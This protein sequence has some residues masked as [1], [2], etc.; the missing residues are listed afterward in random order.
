MGNPRSAPG[1]FLN[2]AAIQPLM[3]SAGLNKYSEMAVDTARNG[4][5]AEQP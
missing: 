4:H 1:Q 5:E 3:F 2:L